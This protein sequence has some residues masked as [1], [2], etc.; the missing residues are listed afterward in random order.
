M[1]MLTDIIPATQ[2]AKVYIVFA[3][4]AAGFGTVQVVYLTTSTPQP[5][6]LTVALALIAY[7]GTSMGAL[8]KA[9][10]PMQDPQAAP[11]SPST[12]VQGGVTTF[13]PGDGSP[14]TTTLS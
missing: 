4:I 12:T 7:V 3:V 5:M 9:N 14:T 6:W 2:R 13:D 1:T 11:V 10:V 8:A